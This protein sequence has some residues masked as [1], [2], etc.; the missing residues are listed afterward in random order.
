MN[1][2]TTLTIATIAI[3]AVMLA[4]SPMVTNP[5]FASFSGSKGKGHTTEET[6][7]SP[8]ERVTEGDC[9]GQSEKSGPHQESE[10][11]FAG[12]SNQPKDTDDTEDLP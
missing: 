10:T 11:T 12:K 8:N 5:A 7:T 6:C 4:I 2:K 3:A 1:S 9:K